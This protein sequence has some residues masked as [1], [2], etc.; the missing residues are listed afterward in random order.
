M[1]QTKTAHPKRSAEEILKA[2]HEQVERGILLNPGQPKS[3]VAEW[4]L[5]ET[6]ADL[7][8]D[9]SR[10]LLTRDFIGQVGRFY[11]AERKQDREKQLELTF[12]FPELRERV[13]FLPIKLRA[14]ETKRAELAKWIRAKK[15]ANSERA[16]SDPAVLAAEAILK[17]WPKRAPGAVRGFR[18]MGLGEVDAIKAKKAGLL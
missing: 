1:V 9:Y 10:I 6:E 15:A 4:L 11:L 14:P 2:V 8:V 17:A 12:H 5:R 13:R 7:L 16:K 3:N 18:Q